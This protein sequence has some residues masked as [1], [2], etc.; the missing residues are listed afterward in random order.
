VGKKSD[1]SYENGGLTLRKQ[2][3]ANR[4]LWWVA[5][6]YD[7]YPRG[8]HRSRLILATEPFVKAK[9]AL[10]E[11]VEKRR[12]LQRQAAAYTVGE[13]WE[14]WLKE[15]AK[16][17]YSNKIY[18]FQWVAMKPHFEKRTAILLTTDDCRA[19]AQARFDAGCRPATVHTEL[20]RLR[21]C[22]HWAAESRSYFGEQ[23]PPKIWV[24]ASGKPRS[25]VLTPDEAWRIITAARNEGDPHIYV[26]IVLLFTTGA[27]HTA[28]LELEWDRV[29]FAAGTI[30][31]ED[32]M[33]YDPMSKA[34]KKG[35]GHVVM[36]KLAREALDE[37]YPGRSKCGFVIEHG[38]R[39][40]K[41]CREGFAWACVRAGLGEAAPSPCPSN[42]NKVRPVTDITPHTIRHTVASWLRGKVQTAFTA[43][44]LGHEDEET[45]RKVYE[46]ADA[47]A[48]RPAVQIIDATFD[49]L[50]ELPSKAARKGSKRPSGKQSRSIV[51]ENDTASE[52]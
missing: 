39:R 21:A 22:I 30:K 37:I 29:D 31:F 27:R 5:E 4:V 52:R 19:Y 50:P 44:L 7:A 6:W 42:P 41:T 45:T 23:L 48:T 35:R 51:D 24:P 3:D 32:E 36:S 25:R 47:E 16:D 2:I 38:G 33:V 8:R 34:W 12:A 15:R 18:Q 20:S 26:F 46:H 11:L 14:D 1:E 43:S 9:S 10:D 49:A 40:L 13:I 17:G 28:I